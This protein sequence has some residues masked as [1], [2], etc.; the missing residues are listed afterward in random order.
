MSAL[1]EAALAYARHGWPVFPLRPR[2]KEPLG[3]LAPHGFKD[4]SRDPDVVV[5]WWEQYPEANIGVP[6]GRAI[7]A[8]VLD[9][10]CKNGARGLETYEHLSSERAVRETLQQIT[11]SGGKQLFFAI[12]GFDVPCLGQQRT[13]AVG[14]DG[15]DVKG[16]GGYV[17]VPPSIHPNTGREYAWDGLKEFDEQAVLDAPQ[18]VL[19][20]L[21]KLINGAARERKAAPVEGAIPEGRRN[22]VLFRLAASL[23]VKG[24][25]EAAI[26]AALI[27]ENRARCSP[28][29]S[30]EEVRRIAASA[31]KYEQG[32]DT[33]RASG[34]LTA[35]VRIDDPTIDDL[36]RLAVWAGRITFSAVR[37]RGQAVEA[38]TSSGRVIRWRNM[39]ELGSFAKAQ[40]AIAA[41]AGV[42]L[43]TPPRNKIRAWW[44]AAATLLVALGEQNCTPVG[45]PTVLEA[46]ALL[47]ET[48]ETVGCPK[49]TDITNMGDLI[50]EVKRYERWG[51]DQHAYPPVVFLAEGAAWVHPGKWRIWLSTPRGLNRHYAMVELYDF[52]AALDFSK[53]EDTTR[54]TK[55]GQTVK[56]DLWRGDVRWLTGFTGITGVTGG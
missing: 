7:N 47:R 23:R 32:E 18:V 2:G 22:D 6:T 30:D 54:R 52:L 43:P 8:W 33:G 42:W 24:L 38:L 44:D 11:G 36:N 46:E 56:C 27:E 25:S 40:Q 26:R 9:L 53:A 16:E 29:L 4:A 39:A 12:P 15:C 50:A 28:P 31:A 17:V 34:V 5:R 19:D 21:A 55:A 3:A 20:A 49:E 14:L 48:W 41:G 35:E 10:D 51:H 13:A 1:S 37:R 45:D